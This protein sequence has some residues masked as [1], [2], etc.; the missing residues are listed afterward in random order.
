MPRTVLFMSDHKAPQVLHV[1]GRVL[2]G[3]E[4][5]RDELWVVDGRIS[6]GRAV[7]RTRR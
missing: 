3:P 6:Y 1:K 2:V 7:A 5:V 4:D